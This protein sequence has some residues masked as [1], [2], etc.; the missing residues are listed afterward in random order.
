[1]NN[2]QTNHELV[3]LTIGLSQEQINNPNRNPK[4]A[5]GLPNQ[6]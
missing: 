6:K 4:S 1:M 2:L 5:R 3:S